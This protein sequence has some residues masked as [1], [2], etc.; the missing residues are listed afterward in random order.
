MEK[1]QSGPYGKSELQAAFGKK[2][3]CSSTVPLLQKLS[4]ALQPVN[5]IQTFQGSPHGP[6][7]VRYTLVSSG[8][9][10]ASK[11]PMDSMFDRVVICLALH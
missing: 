11:S 8:G 1:A 5:P 6:D 3:Q 10:V 4:L 7:F 9:V 2:A